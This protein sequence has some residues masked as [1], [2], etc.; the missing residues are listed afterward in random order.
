MMT[1]EV[2]KLHLLPG[3]RKT[4][5]CWAHGES[6]E[7]EGLA[8]GASWSSTAQDAC[9]L[10][11]LDGAVVII[12]A[13]APGAATIGVRH[14]TTVDDV[15]YVTVRETLWEGRQDTNWSYLPRKRP[16]AVVERQEPRLKRVEKVVTDFIRVIVHDPAE[17]PPLPHVLS[18]GI[19]EAP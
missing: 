1:I 6:G 2:R 8:T 9:R 4:L 19:T 5:T 15:E 17:A 3:Q 18:I 14:A 16:D 13:L 10:D 7:V 11:R 12:E